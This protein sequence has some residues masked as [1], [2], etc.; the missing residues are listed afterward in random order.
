MTI[1]KVPESYIQRKLAALPAHGR[2]GV[3]LAIDLAAVLTGPTSGGEA[4]RLVALLRASTD[5]P[6]IARTLREIADRYDP[7]T[8]STALVSAAMN[9][10]PWL[11]LLGDHIGNGTPDDPNGRCDA[12]L[13]LREAI[14]E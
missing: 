2:P 7:P 12:I 13:A 5:D 4:D 8:K 9:A 14:D 10:I 1:H 3:R 6:E 11:I